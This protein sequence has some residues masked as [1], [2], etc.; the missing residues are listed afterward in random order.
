MKIDLECLAFGHKFRCERCGGRRKPLADWDAS[1]QKLVEIEAECR[2]REW[3]GL[4]AVIDPEL[5]SRF[6]ER[7][8]GVRIVSEKPFGGG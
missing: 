3:L 6:R 1:I 8:L 5:S 2:L 4:V 7:L